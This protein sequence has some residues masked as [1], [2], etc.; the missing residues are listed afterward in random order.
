MQNCHDTAPTWKQVKTIFPCIIV[1][2]P[3]PQWC[4][5]LQ[6]SLLQIMNLIC[7]PRH[8]EGWQTLLAE[9]KFI[10]NQPF[11]LV[12]SNIFGKKNN[13]DKWTQII[14]CLKAVQNSTYHSLCLCSILIGQKVISA[15]YMNTLTCNPL[16]QPYMWA[17][18]RHESMHTETP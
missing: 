8:A 10:R 11:S 12:W 5:K 6:R 14:R 2:L 4:Q 3:C 16:L 13:T 17:S 15:H 7:T 9:I 18:L 1:L